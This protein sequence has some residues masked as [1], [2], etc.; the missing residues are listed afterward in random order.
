MLDHPAGKI[1]VVGRVR[2][3]DG[4]VRIVVRATDVTLSLSRPN[5]ISVRTML[6]GTIAGIEREACH[7]VV[8][9][10]W[11]SPACRNPQHSRFEP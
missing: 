4:Q 6:K 7:S 5:E 11:A 1:T 10:V 9:I 8:S 2:P 3:H